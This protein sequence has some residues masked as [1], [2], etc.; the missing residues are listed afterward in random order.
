MKKF[1]TVTSSLASLLLFTLPFIVLAHTGVGATT[2]FS[3]GF[4]H[5][6]SGIDHML[7]MLGV[8]VWASQLSGRRRFLVPAA[9]VGTMQIG[10]IF[11]MA[12]VPF[13]MVELGIAGSVIAVGMLMALEMKMKTVYAALL[14]GLMAFFHGH[15]HGTEI[16]LAASGALYAAG[17]TFS[18]ICL[19]VFGVA[20]G[21]ALRSL[22][23]Q[24]V[25]RAVG[26][27]TAVAGFVLLLGA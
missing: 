15:A 9:F 20:L 22:W 5:P 7:A 18:T 10:G 13:P 24:K 6:F 27:A 26:V 2:G 23:Q 11:G 16:P 1:T 25:L 17:F 14:V 12:H 8:G 19:H 4:W 3:H 21:D